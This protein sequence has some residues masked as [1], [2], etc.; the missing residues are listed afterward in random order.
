MLFRGDILLS[1]RNGEGLS[2]VE[3]AQKVNITQEYWHALERGK[4]VPSLKL[5]QVIS[6]VTGLKKSVLLG[7]RGKTACLIR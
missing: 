1:W 4:R 2:Q 7:E 6:E 3:S 5:L